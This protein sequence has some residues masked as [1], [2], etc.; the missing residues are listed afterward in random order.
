MKNRRPGPQAGQAL[1]AILGANASCLRPSCRQKARASRVGLAALFGFLFW[2]LS[3][4]WLPAQ[5][6]SSTAPDYS[7]GPDWFPNVLRPYQSQKITPLPTS[8]P[9]DLFALAVNGTL[10]L[11]LAQLRSA[12]LGNNLD[13]AAVSDN[14]SMADTDVLRARG[15][16]APRGAPGVRIPSGLFAG[17]IG[18][19]VG[20]T[21]T[22]GGSGGA[23]G[24]TGNARQV[25]ARPRGSYDPSI[26]LNFS[27]DK[28]TS[29][30]N[31]VVVA[32]LPSVETSTTA[33]QARF[34]QAFTTGTSV[35]VSFNNQRQNSTQRFLR[36]NPSVVSTFSLVVTQQL[37]NGF[38][39]GVNRRFLTVAERGKRISAEAARQQVMTTLSQA[40]SLYW[41]LVAAR[42]NVEVARQALAVAEQLLRDNTIREEL[43]AISRMEVFTAASEVAARRRDLIA[44]Q[45]VFDSREAD[46]KNLLTRDFAKASESIRI[47]PIDSL[48]EPTDTPP[49]LEDLLSEAVRNRPEIL[50]AEANLENQEVAIRY[51]RNLLKPTFLVFGMLNSSGLYG[52]R[53]IDL[54]TGPAVFPGGFG[55]AF[56]QVSHFEYPEYAFGFSL[57]IPLLNRSAQADHYRARIELAQS[58]TALEQTRSRIHFE[59]RDAL[60]ALVQTSAQVQSARKAVELQEKGLQQ[61]QEKLMAGLS[62]PYEVI[63][64]QRDLMMAQFEEVRARASHAKARVELDRATGRTR[65]K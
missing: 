51:T 26:A 22:V 16:G 49:Q 36:F 12:V 8:D 19:G 2:V 35:S 18:A 44:A 24:I 65:E 13:I 28:T 54:V 59:V 7:R 10:R 15:G 20:D 55:Q 40:E 56:C 25:S 33:L 47:D 30:L 58:Q 5:Q 9:V 52:N 64:R 61:E 21:T 3:T 57:Q 39:R 38:G 23:G 63:R 50:Q 6:V 14:S 32:G 11:S 17:A 27:V 53:L 62:T 4:A 46:L 42:D 29:P 37:M 45:A 60:T 34:A 43:G 48:P 1:N 41:D 31:T